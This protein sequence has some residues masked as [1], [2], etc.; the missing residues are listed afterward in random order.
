M[1][2]T[3][4]VARRPLTVSTRLVNPVRISPLRLGRQA[5]SCATRTCARPPH[6]LWS[7]APAVQSRPSRARATAGR[8][9]ASRDVAT[10]PLVPRGALF[11]RSVTPRAITPLSMQCVRTTRH[12]HCAQLSGPSRTVAA[13][14]APPPLR[15]PMWPRGSG[16]LPGPHLAPPASTS[17]PHPPHQDPYPLVQSHPLRRVVRLV[18]RAHRSLM[19]FD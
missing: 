15:A 14:R 2:A 11:V 12:A 3:V 8:Q 6:A 13:A 17:F 19:P 10:R 18:S 16:R 7:R 1:T 5:S 9:A 4:H